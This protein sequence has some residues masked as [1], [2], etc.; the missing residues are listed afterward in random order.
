MTNSRL[1]S[2]VKRI[3]SLEEEQRAL[4]ADKGDLYAEAKGAG[5]NVKA[6]RK[7]IR[8]R[9]ED[10]AQKAEIEAAMDAYRVELGMVAASV[11]RGEISERNA[12]KE[13]GF[14]ASAIHRAAASLKKDA[15]SEAPH[16]DAQTFDEIAGPLPPFL[17][18][19]A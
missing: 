18:R 3:E 4:G 11:A 12:A 9:K 2:I 14:S 5:Y 13:S 7:L 17:K 10:T 8:E 6:L 15:V 19:S 1:Q 16:D